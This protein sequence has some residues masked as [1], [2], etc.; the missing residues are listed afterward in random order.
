[1]IEIN[2]TRL[3][4]AFILLL[5]VLVNSNNIYVKGICLLLFILGLIIYVIKWRKKKN[6]ER[7]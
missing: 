5:S 2:I 6:E 4:G 3:I 7:L 1:M